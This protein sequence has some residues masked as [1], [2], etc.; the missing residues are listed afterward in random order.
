MVYEPLTHCCHLP[1]TPPGVL[2]SELHL[3]MPAL[4]QGTPSQHPGVPGYWQLP[5]LWDEG[6]KGLLGLKDG[7]SWPLPFADVLSLTPG[8]SP[9][10]GLMQKLLAPAARGLER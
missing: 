7:R 8:P 9:D 2:C 4:S 1:E 3:L 10:A 6:S 5:S